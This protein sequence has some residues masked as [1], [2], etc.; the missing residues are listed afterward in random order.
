MFHR[1]YIIGDLMYIDVR[2]AWGILKFE[3]QKV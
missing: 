2:S 3:E 1:R